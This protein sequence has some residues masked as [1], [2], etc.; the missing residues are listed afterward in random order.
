M[1]KR[2]YNDV[3]IVGDA[4]GRW[5]G[6]FQVYVDGV[7]MNWVKSVEVFLSPEDLPVVKLVF[8]PGRVDLEGQLVVEEKAGEYEAR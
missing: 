3:R 5:P 4:D 7:E 8:M 6:A 1:A 2:P